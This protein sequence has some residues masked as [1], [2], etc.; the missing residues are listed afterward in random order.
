MA[1]IN[2]RGT[3]IHSSELSAL[4]DY[5]SENRTRVVSITMWG[6]EQHP[7][8]QI[9]FRW[10]DGATGVH[11]APSLRTLFDIVEAR[12]G[13]PK[14]KVFGPSLPRTA[15]RLWAADFELTEEPPEKGQD[16]GTKRVVRQRIA[17]AGVVESGARV[18]RTRVQNQNQSRAVM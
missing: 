11:V 12:T 13:W 8:G 6:F 9:A 18:R 15:A 3:M 7:Y 1:L 2:R 10:A 17:G 14:P 16:V 5:G 4:L